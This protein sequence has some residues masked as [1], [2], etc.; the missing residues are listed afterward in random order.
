VE[1]DSGK[2]RKPKPYEKWNHGE[3]QVLVRLWAERSGRLESKDARK[4][5]DDIA[6]SLAIQPFVA[7]K[8]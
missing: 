3:Q 5:W 2:K 8:C 4:F 7:V 1:E 6:D